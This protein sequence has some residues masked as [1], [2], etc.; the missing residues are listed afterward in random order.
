MKT[1][2]KFA[3]IDGPNARAIAEAV[4]KFGASIE[5]ANQS[6]AN[7]RQHIASL[8]RGEDFGYP[9]FGKYRSGTQA[10]PCKLLRRISTTC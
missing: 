10:R 7:A 9:F 1:K 4:S 6:V 5:E 3:V 2:T 8:V